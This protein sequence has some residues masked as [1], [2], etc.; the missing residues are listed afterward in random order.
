M[1]R[2]LSCLFL[3]ISLAPFAALAVEKITVLGLFKDKAIVNVDG[4]QRVLTVG[5]ASPEGVLLISADSE[6]AVIEVDGQ[7]TSYGLGTHISSIYEKP[8]DGPVVQI[9]PDSY[10]MYNIIGNINSYPVTFLVDTGATLIAMNKNE[11]RRLG[12]DYLISGIPSQASTASGVVSTY[13]VKLNKVRVGDITLHNV[14]ASVIDGDFPTEVLLSNSFLNRLEMRR[15]GK[16]LELKK[17]Y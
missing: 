5:K 11:A 9:W 4:K 8:A 3:Y 2:F 12:L 14:D 17:N 6:E 16:M 10:G 15:Q 7:T 13:L 1:R